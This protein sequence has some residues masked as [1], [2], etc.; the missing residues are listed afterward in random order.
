MRKLVLA[1]VAIALGWTSGASALP[2]NNPITAGLI[3]AYEFTGNADDVSGNG[4]DGVVNG[5]TLTADRFGNA[6]AAYSF[7]G[8]DDYIISSSTFS[9]QTQGS[10]AFWFRDT[11]ANGVGGTFVASRS[12]S[13]YENGD[14]IIGN[15]EGGDGFRN[16]YWGDGH[17]NGWEGGLTP[18]INSWH[19]SVLTWDTTATSHLYVDSIE[20][21]PAAPAFAIFAGLPLVFGRDQVFHFGS[22]VTDFATGSIDDAYIYNRALSPSEVSTLYSVVP[23]PSTALLLGVGLAGMAARRRV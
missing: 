6:N 10:I 20:I 17:W 18:T 5:A 1:V 21:T 13:G 14:L 19:H 8:V 22:W 11:S 12:T 7:D 4:N 15:N 16:I 3:A 2:A 23:E 9:Q